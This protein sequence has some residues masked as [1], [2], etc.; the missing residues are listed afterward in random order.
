MMNLAQKPVTILTGFLGAGKTTLLN[1]LLQQNQGI[2]Y[3]IIENEFGE[4]GIDSELV[5]R[6][7]ETIVEL[8][9]GCLC[10]TLNDNL[11][12]ILN[13]LFDRRDDFDEIIIEATG[14]ADPTG[15][16]QPFVS[17][18]LIKEHFP[19]Q[20]VICLVDAELIE[21]H[22]KETEEAKNQVAYSDVLLINKTDLVSPDYV[23]E[24]TARLK[25]L[26]PLARIL[27]GSK[28][29]FPVIEAQTQESPLEALLLPADGHAHAVGTETEFPVAKPHSHHHHHHTEEII[30]HSFH[31][32]QPFDLDML[33]QQL[34]VYLMVQSGVYRI[35]A[36]VSPGTTNERY[37][38][39]SVGKRLDVEAKGTW[40]EGDKRQSVF[41]FIGKKL[42]RDGIEQLLSQCLRKRST[43]E[44]TDV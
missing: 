38:V 15:L 28:G 6:P 39:Q 29:S 9:N 8:N 41:V 34:F 13:D 23:E 37:L 42:K 30:S 14:V 18:P 21:D 5:V 40:P 10:C 32:D 31:F 26:N 33:E 43:L 4:Q 12:D 19:L 17:H 2:R 3:A 20:A 11:Y 24:L 35:K 16:A 27:A 7:E 1:H 25:Q 44:N 36:L 22:L